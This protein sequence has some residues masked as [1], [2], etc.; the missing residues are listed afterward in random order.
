M[1][2]LQLKLNENLYTKDPQSTELGRKIINEGIRLIDI[3][4][5]EAFTFKK[6]SKEIDSTEAS[7]YRYFDN[8][9]RLLVYLIS[10]YWNW[11][12]YRI[13]FETH[14]VPDPYDRLSVALKILTEQKGRDPNFPEVDES[15]LQRIVIAE[16]DK[17][18]LIKEVDEVNKEGIFRG[19]KSLCGNIASI[20]LEI[21]PDF[22]NPH[23]LISTVLE[24][25]NQQIFFAQHLPS[26][27]NL[28]KDNEPFE[29]NFDFL[30]DLV[31]QTIQPK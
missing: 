29:H 12:E 15:A 3:L 22:P 20:V 31:F 7:I 28:K 11:L 24:A 1:T 27:T 16:S 5:F 17:T 23:S 21:N 19:Y 26:L 14:N 4:G 8:K 10:W 18:Y 2:I 25:S 13:V 30:K 6:L 9:H